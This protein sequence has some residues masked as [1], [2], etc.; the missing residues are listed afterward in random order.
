VVALLIDK[1]A[2][3]NAKDRDGKT[4]LSLAQEKGHNEIIELLKKR[5][6]KEE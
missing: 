3:V 1:G 5:G 2:D 6:A 4:P